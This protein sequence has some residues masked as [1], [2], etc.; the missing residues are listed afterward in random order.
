[1]TIR[2]PE[3]SN[4]IQDT[5]D[6][7]QTLIEDVYPTIDLDNQKEVDTYDE[8]LGEAQAANT[9]VYAAALDSQTGEI[10]RVAVGKIGSISAGDAMRKAHLEAAAKSITESADGAYGGRGRA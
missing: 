3:L 1:M 6:T 2:S 4:K 5:S 7:I 10:G 9:E 8:L